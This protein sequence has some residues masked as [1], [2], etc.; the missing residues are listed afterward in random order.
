MNTATITAM[1]PALKLEAH[2]F[3][4]V[5]SELNVSDQA[6]YPLKVA[7]PTWPIDYWF[8]RLVLSEDY[9]Y[10]VTKLDG[11]TLFAFYPKQEP[12]P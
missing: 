6:G 10:E 2:Y 1:V 11:R 3:I 9:T 7:D 12:K 8:E 4:L 5:G